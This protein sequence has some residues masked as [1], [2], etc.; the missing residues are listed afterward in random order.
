MV[1]KLENWTVNGHMWIVIINYLGF[2]NDIIQLL[3]M[4]WFENL[5]GILKFTTSIHIYTLYRDT[6]ES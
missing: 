5:V 2:Y 3:A 6:R 4:N 1:K